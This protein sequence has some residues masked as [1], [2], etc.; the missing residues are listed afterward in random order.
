MKVEIGDLI[1]LDENFTL[2]WEQEEAKP[3]VPYR[4]TKVRWAEGHGVF[5]QLRGVYSSYPETAIKKVIK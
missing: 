3:G 1:Y 2:N 4:V 5:V